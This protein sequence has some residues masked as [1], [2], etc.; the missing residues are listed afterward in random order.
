MPDGLRGRIAAAAKANG[1]SMNSE[2][3]SV[4]EEAFPTPAEDE[5]LMERIQEIVREADPDQLETMFR[6]LERLNQS[7]NPEPPTKKRA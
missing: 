2:I 6:M 4:L 5:A 1:R 3:I 7:D